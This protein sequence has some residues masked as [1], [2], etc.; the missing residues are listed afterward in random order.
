[1]HGQPIG[2]PKIA[3][4][5]MIASAINENLEVTSSG[6][7]FKQFG[8]SF[9]RRLFIRSDR[10]PRRLYIWIDADSIVQERGQRFRDDSTCECPET[11]WLSNDLRRN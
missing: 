7:L 11:V 10:T 2:T 9:H 4:Q 5:G 1:M 6:S 3:L 8:V